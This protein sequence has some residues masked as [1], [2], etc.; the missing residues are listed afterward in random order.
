MIIKNSYWPL[1]ISSLLLLSIGILV[2]FS[3]SQILAFQQFIYALV[4]LFLF[5]FLAGFDYRILGNFT[6]PAMLFILF[7][8]V[9]VFL[10]GFETRGSLR[11][12]P[13]GFFNIQPSEFAKPVLIVFLAYFWS[14]HLATWKNIGL[15]LIWTLPFLALIFKQPDLGT[16]LTLSSIWFI[17]LFTSKI[18][19]KKVLMILLIIVMVVP[20]GWF[21]LRDYQKQR[22]STFL[23]PGADPLGQGYNIIQST[24]AV[25]SGYIWGRGLGRGTQSRLQF[26]PE[27]RTDF[28]FAAIAEELGFLGSMLIVLI[29]L[30]IVVYCFKVSGQSDD[31]FGSLVASGVAGMILFQTVV[32]VGMNIGLL[33]VTGITLPL[34]SYGGSSLLAT[35]ISLGLV[36]SVAKLRRDR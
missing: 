23:S 3:S 35:L 9:I 25:G 30:Y 10:I 11:W 8:L 17:L 12:I 5:F 19:F 22:V 29:Y 27:Y 20:I 2:I 34:L 36:S 7:L 18:S 24:I 33:P 15:S 26:L 1:F 13:L 21:T 31:Y 6:K 4:G 16:T 32:N 14:N 28:I